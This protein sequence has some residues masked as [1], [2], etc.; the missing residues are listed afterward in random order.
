MLAAIVSVVA[1]QGHGLPDHAEEDPEYPVPRLISRSNAQQEEGR[2]GYR[3]TPK[4]FVFLV[5]YRA[6]E[7]TFFYSNHCSAC[8]PPIQSGTG[9]PLASLAHFALKSDCLVLTFV[10]VRREKSNPMCIHCTA[11]VGRLRTCR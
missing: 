10:S 3:V 5:R 8:A 4:L 6:R 7:R 11:P 9:G 2:R 1:E